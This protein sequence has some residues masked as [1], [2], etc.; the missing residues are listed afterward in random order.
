M[1]NISDDELGA[2]R[3]LESERVRLGDVAAVADLLAAAAQTGEALSPAAARLLAEALR[4]AARNLRGA[5][6]AVAT[7]R[8]EA[9]AAESN[10]LTASQK[11]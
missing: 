2:L 10:C 11:S 8:E 3:E 6:D 5:F 9:A 4:D 1:P 7:A